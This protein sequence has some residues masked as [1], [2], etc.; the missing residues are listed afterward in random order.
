MQRAGLRQ[1]HCSRQ[2]HTHTMCICWV[3]QSN[4]MSGSARLQK[5]AVFSNEWKY[6]LLY[7]EEYCEKVCLS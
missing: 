1:R 6:V 4:E 7:G 2:L 5:C 3:P